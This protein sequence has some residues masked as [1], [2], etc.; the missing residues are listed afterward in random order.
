MSHLHSSWSDLPPFPLPRRLS[1][2]LLPSRGLEHPPNPRTA[3][4]FGRLA[5]QSPL[6]GHEPNAIVEISSTQVPLVHRPSRRASFCSEDNG[7]EDTTSAP[8]S[9]GVDER[10]S[11]GRPA[12]H[13][14]MKKRRMCSPCA[15]LSLC[16]KNQGHIHLTFRAEGDLLQHTHTNRSRAE[17]QEAHRRHISVRTDQ[18]EA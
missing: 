6:T 5:I 3:G 7:G 8:V 10:Q 13:L 1:S 9:S 14:L 16:W 4:R 18:Q 12:S 11:I 15:D 2:L 17:T